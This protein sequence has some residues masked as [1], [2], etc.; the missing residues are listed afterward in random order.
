VFISSLAGKAATPGSALYNASKFGLRGFASALRADLHDTGV[1]VSAVFPGFIRDAG[2]FADAGV[3]LPPGL[4]TRT[5]D[6]VARA[7]LSVIE[8]NRGELD[9]APFAL[10]ASAAFA[11][12]APELAAGMARRLGSARIS[13]EMNAGQRAK[14]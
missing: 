2:M 3:A 8:H 9:C 5:P 4:G 14:R 12:L 1:G 11:G 10:R 7:V 13:R 6:D